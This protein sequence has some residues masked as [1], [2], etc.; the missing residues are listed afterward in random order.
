[1]FTRDAGSG[2]SEKEE[3]CEVRSFLKLV[4]KFKKLAVKGNASDKDELQAAYEFGAMLLNQLQ[5]QITDL[6]TEFGSLSRKSSHQA[7]ACARDIQKFVT[8]VDKVRKDFQKVP[9]PTPI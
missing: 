3:K 5:S 8:D 2:D 9:G 1:M 6:L 7:K 4:P